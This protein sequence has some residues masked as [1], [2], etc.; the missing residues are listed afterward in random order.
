MLIEN[1]FKYTKVC[2]SRLKL[3]LLLSLHR[4]NLTNLLICHLQLAGEYHE[5]KRRRC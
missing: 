3:F 5:S 2:S 4:I 1:Y